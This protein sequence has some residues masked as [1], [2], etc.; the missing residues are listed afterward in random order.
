MAK[1]VLRD[2]GQETREIEVIVLTNWSCNYHCPFCF[3]GDKKTDKT[4]ID[5]KQLAKQILEIKMQ[6]NIS[7][8]T[9]YGGEI[10]MLGF[11]FFEQIYQILA[12]IAQICVITNLSDVDYC[13]AIY[14]FPG[15]RIGTSLNQERDHYAETVQNL[16][17]IDISVDIT[18]VVTPS[19][20]K[21]DPKILLDECQCIGRNIEFIQYSKSQSNQFQYNISNREY[22]IFINHI[23]DTYESNPSYS[24]KLE[25]IERIQAAIR[26]EYSPTMENLIFITPDNQFASIQYDKDNKEYFKKYAELLDWQNDCLREKNRYVAKCY[27]CK[28]YGH[29]LAEHI[30]DWD[31]ED[32][33]CG[34]KG[35]LEHYEDL[36]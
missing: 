34:M 28:Y 27:G 19:I 7:S 20:L 29:C 23:V 3:L 16:M 22:E 5:L 17:R 31:S 15:V 12:P 33:C 10:S 26:G 35:I 4:C 24:F 18:S 32:E 30:R 21:K 13:R 14:R 11:S 1:T 25:N 8:F 2:I 36:H 6:Y 9:L